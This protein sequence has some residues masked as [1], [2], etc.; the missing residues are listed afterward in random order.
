MKFL[1]TAFFITFF[2]ACKTSKNTGTMEN[3]HEL[4]KEWKISN[5]E[6]SG[7]TQILRPAGF[8]LPPA[9]LRE[10]F[11]FHP[12]NTLTYKTLD[13]VDLPLTKKGRWEWAD[14]NTLKLIIDD[15]TI[16]FW[17]IIKLDENKMEVVR[18]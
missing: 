6:G 16:I 2:V 3:S 8:D 13:A 4:L 5:E 15:E 9:R 12:D 1:F 17:K 18:Q 7:E 14:E 10:E 11:V